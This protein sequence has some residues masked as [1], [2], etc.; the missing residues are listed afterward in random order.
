MSDLGIEMG[1]SVAPTR[2]DIDT[3]GTHQCVK[4]G[5]K[6]TGRLN[7]YINMEMQVIGT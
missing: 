4:T 2:V 7:F 6:A 3:L 1:R 5:T